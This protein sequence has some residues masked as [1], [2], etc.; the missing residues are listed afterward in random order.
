MCSYRRSTRSWPSLRPGFCR[1]VG[2]PPAFPYSLLLN[3]SSLPLL[4]GCRKIAILDIL[5][6]QASSA[7]SELI[8]SSAQQGYTIEAESYAL[9]VTREE[10]VKTVFQEIVHKWGRIDCLVA[11]AGKAVTFGLAK[12][13]DRYATFRFGPQLSCLRVRITRL[14]PSDSYGALMIFVIIYADTPPV[15]STSSTM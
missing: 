3:H 15:N 2:E 8:N 6:D 5:A 14:V 13:S 12:S 1:I 4:S 11:S 7:A 10:N 9:D